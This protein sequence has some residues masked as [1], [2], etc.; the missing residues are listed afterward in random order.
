MKGHKV[1]TIKA[2][3]KEQEDGGLPTA[4]SSPLDPRLLELVRFM[5]RCAAQHDFDALLREEGQV[6]E[7]G[8]GKEEIT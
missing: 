7:H 1:L 5:A 3:N 6:S 4:K 2:D 8:G